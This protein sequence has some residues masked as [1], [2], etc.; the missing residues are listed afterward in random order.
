MGP[1]SRVRQ[2]NLL[3][4][5]HRPNGLCNTKELLG[6]LRRLD[7]D[8]IFEEMRPSDTNEYYKTGTKWSVESQAIGVF[9]KERSVVQVPV[10]NFDGAVALFAEVNPLFDFVD[11]NSY[12]YVAL[13]EER[14]RRA[15][16]EGYGFLNSGECDAMTRRLREIFERT[17]VDSRQESLIRALGKWN[18]MNMAREDAMLTNIYTFCKNHKFKNGTFLVGAAHRETIIGA[19]KRQNAAA[20]VSIDWSWA[21]S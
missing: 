16:S 8:V 3:C 18:V 14:G 5:V 21:E 12:E 7:P 2:I 9:S 17:I 20:S 15:Y 11:G 19:I 10:D 1:S 4:T 13:H 6:M